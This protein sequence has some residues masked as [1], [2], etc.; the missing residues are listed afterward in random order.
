M[1]VHKHTRQRSATQ[2]QTHT[3]TH[4]GNKPVNK[5]AADSSFTESYL[6]QE[7]MVTEQGCVP[8]TGAHAQA[9]TLGEVG[10][11]LLG[12]PHVLVDLVHALLHPLQLLWNT[13]STPPSHRLIP[14][15]LL[16]Q[17]HAFL[18]L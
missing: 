3:L 8:V 17:T 16:S 6:L 15:F 14:L 11:V 2:M 10:Q 13:R 12:H 18:S 5:A 4:T 9:A 7:T 1:H